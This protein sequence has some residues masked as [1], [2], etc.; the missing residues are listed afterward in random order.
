VPYATGTYRA[1]AWTGELS[2]LEIHES[3]PQ[4]V[5]F[6]YTFESLTKPAARLTLSR[7]RARAQGNKMVAAPDGCFVELAQTAD[8]YHTITMNTRQCAH[9]VAL[10]RG[11]SAFEFRLAGVGV[12]FEGAYLSGDRKTVLS[13]ANLSAPLSTSPEKSYILFWQGGKG[14]KLQVDRTQNP[15]VTTSDVSMTAGA[16]KTSFAGPDCTLAVRFDATGGHVAQ[17]GSCNS[18]FSS[19]TNADANLNVAGDYTAF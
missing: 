13:V 7:V 16:A 5:V 12:P 10:G 2:T 14:S 15:Y 3:T 1:K 11:S 9:D 4:A 18:T 8:A 17:V 6:S 19:G